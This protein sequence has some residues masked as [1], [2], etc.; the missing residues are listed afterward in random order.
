MIGLLVTP[1]IAAA[2]QVPTGNTILG[3]NAGGATLRT[4]I[5]SIVDIINRIFPILLSL[6]V[7]FFFIG[8]I[9]YITKATDT[10]ARALGRDT[11]IWSLTG[12]FIIVTLWGVLSLIQSAFFPAP[13]SPNY[14]DLGNPLFAPP[15]MNA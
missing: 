8:L 15:T 9:R 1:F 4:L 12:L 5:L 11:I 2:Q 14:N 6:A 13:A 3:M 10:K 7:V